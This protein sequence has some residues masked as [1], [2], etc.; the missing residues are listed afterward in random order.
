MK[1]WFHAAQVVIGASGSIQLLFRCL[2]WWT[3]NWWR[4]HSGQLEG[5]FGNYPRAT[6]S[7]FQIAVCGAA[8]L[9]VVCVLFALSVLCP[10]RFTWFAG[11]VC[12]ALSII[13][14]GCVWY[15]EVGRYEVWY[16]FVTTPDSVFSLVLLVNALVWF[17][18]PNGARRQV[19]SA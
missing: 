3:N 6:D 13:D 19:A 10:G 2:S 5:N 8:S 11:T 1:R 4:N 9:A 16:G 15:E 17:K 12:V 7:G 18:I 14:V